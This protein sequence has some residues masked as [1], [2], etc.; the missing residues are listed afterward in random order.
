MTRRSRRRS[1]RRNSSPRTGKPVGAAPDGDRPH[2]TALRVRLLDDGASAELVHPRCAAQRRED[3]EE[4]EAML[5]AGE[6]EVARDEL[7]WLLD[8][9][10]DLVEA[11][12]KLGEIA[13]AEGDVPLA[14][15]HFGYACQVC[16][17]ALRGRPLVRLPY[18][19]A[20]NRAFFEAA[21]GAAWCLAQLGRRQD[22]ERIAERML[23]LDP[24]DPLGFGT[25]RQELDA[26]D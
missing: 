23:A 22:A 25:L 11:H 21:K 18:E 13:V 5:S 10:S 12:L 16:E 8:G 2:A 19:L 4:V 3:L 20:A 9:C 17:A 26:A 6:F 7:R 14:R 15:G 24:S 1:D